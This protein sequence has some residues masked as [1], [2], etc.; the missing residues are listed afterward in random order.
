MNHGYAFRWSLLTQA[1]DI[2]GAHAAKGGGGK[3]RLRTL[4][5]ISERSIDKLTEIAESCLEEV[6]R[7]PDRWRSPAGFAEEAVRRFAMDDGVYAHQIAQLSS[8][9]DFP[10]SPA[11]FAT[12]VKRVDEAN[13][14]D[15]KG[16]TL[17]ELAFYL[18]SLLPGCVPQK[19][20]EDVDL[21]FESDIV[22]RNLYRST[23]FLSEL[24]GRYFLVECKN[25]KQRVGVAEVGYFLFR[26]RIT[27]AQFGVIFSKD[28]FVDFLCRAPRRQLK[29]STLGR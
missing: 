20:V 10:I 14:S 25:W 12:L 1:D 23:N 9:D 22:V 8:N 6:K 26:M 11:Y 28:Y 19:N 4:F 5:G 2:L 29:R 15:E 16:K 17:E 24:F 7:I 27:H 21:A 18:F 13:S 3:E